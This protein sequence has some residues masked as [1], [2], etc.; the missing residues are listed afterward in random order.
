SSFEAEAKTAVSAMKSGKALS[1]S[2]AT[3]ASTALATL[4]EVVNDIKETAKAV[5]ALNDAADEQEVVLAEVEDI[6]SNVVRSAERYH[7]LAQR[8][9]MSRSM[10][11]MSDNVEKVVNSLT[12]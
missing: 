10:R 7:E 8:D 9:D 2:N 4:N 6:I 5:V 3:E 11:S 12:R 1:D